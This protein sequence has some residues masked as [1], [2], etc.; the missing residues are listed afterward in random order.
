MTEIVVVVPVLNRPGNVVPLLAS[1]DGAR[2]KRSYRTL[3]VA[4]HGDRAELGA[5]RAAGADF[6]QVR[7][8]VGVVGD[9]ARKINHAYELTDEPFL[10]C[11]ADDLAFHKG[12]ADKLLACAEEHGAGVIGTNDL[13]NTNVMRGDF[14]T[15]PL[16]RRAYIDEHGTIDERGKVLHEGYDHN[17]PDRELAETAKFR[18][19][20]AFCRSAHVEHLHPHW[21]KGTNDA[22][23]VK[24]MRQF[25]RD[26][27]LFDRR[28]RLWAISSR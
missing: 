24:G 8:P 25:N 7:W 13:G 2:R 1:L 21:R 19:Q 22:T 15:H 12:W 26:R 4:S 16:V 18:G 27:L 20:W 3:F 5:L 23:Y 9:W 17:Y 11:A 14:S 10:L 28:S 6:L